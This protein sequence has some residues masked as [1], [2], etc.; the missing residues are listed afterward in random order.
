ML[1]GGFGYFV[2]IITIWCRLQ[3][4]RPVSALARRIF[5]V[6]LG[7]TVL[8][9]ASNVATGF[10]DLTSPWDL[11]V[12]LWTFAWNFISALATFFAPAKWTR[13]AVAYWI[14]TA[15]LLLF[16]LVTG[17]DERMSVLQ[18]FG[19]IVLGFTIAIGAIFA[20][21]IFQRQTKSANV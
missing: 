11:I 7:L 13:F 9:G 4:E 18:R 20:I 2:C 3:V 15:L 1:I 5:V 12:G 6:Y 21:I 16:S 17:D 19:W 8:L 10:I 14:L